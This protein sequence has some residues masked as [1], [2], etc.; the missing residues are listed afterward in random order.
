MRGQFSP[1]GDNGGLE[2]KSL[3][4]SS[5]PVFAGPFVPKPVRTITKKKDPVLAALPAVPGHSVHLIP[6][7]DLV[8]P[9]RLG[10][11]ETS[12]NAGIGVAG[13][14]VEHPHTRPVAGMEPRPVVTG[15]AALDRTGH[16][17][18]AGPA[19][20][21]LARPIA[22][23]HPG[24]RIVAMGRIDGRSQK[25]CGEISHLRVPGRVGT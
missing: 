7:I 21:G 15:Q 12:T 13:A 3:S 4:W 18:I 9:S 25:I 2:S 20:S 10:V 16:G 14:M 5:L 11:E 1:R 17:P 23:G 6:G 8:G 22:D 24:L 19:R